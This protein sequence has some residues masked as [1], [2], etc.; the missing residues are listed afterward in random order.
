MTTGY[1]V[2]LC[3]IFL[4]TAG[5]VLIATLVHGAINLF[6]GVFFGGVAPAN[7]YW[8]LAGVYGLAALV[9]VLVFGPGLAGS[10]RL[11]AI[12]GHFRQGQAGLRR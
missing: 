3:W 7:Q 10:C 11:P 8:L 5:S 2:L 1:S 4:H 12:F 9:I 6:Q